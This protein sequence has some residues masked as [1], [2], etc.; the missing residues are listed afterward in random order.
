MWGIGC[1]MANTYMC[2]YY[3]HVYACV[4]SSECLV[5]VHVKCSG[6][7]V[8]IVY[9]ITAQHYNLTLINRYLCCSVTTDSSRKNNEPGE[10]QWAWRYVYQ[11]DMDGMS[12][13]LI[14]SFMFSRGNKRMWTLFSQP[15]PSSS[16][17]PVLGYKITH[18]TTG[19]S[20]VNQTS[21]TTFFLDELNPGV[22]LFSVWAFNV[23]GDGVEEAVAG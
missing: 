23:L 14:C 19:H 13:L 11:L 2:R 9:T 8:F 12:R 10:S 6:K 1:L 17:P 16:R 15:P 3:V 22:Y 4:Y 20:L 21:D 5:Y 7:Q 18:N